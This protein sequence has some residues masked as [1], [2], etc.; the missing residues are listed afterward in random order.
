[1][2]NIPQTPEEQAAGPSTPPELLR[3]LAESDNEAICQAVAQNSNTPTD[4]LLN[5]FAEFLL[6]VLNNPVL[7]LLLLENPNFFNEL[8]QANRS[9]FRRQDKLPLFFLECNPQQGVPS[10]RLKR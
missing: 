3:E 10:Q 7:D 9:V 8:Y 5:L 4:V 2:S 6:Q 1:M